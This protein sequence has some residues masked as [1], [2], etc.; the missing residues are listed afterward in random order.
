MYFYL[1]NYDELL[2]LLW[3]LKN[4]DRNSC[5]FVFKQGLT[6]IV[7]VP[8]KFDRFWKFN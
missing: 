3:E 2:S 4:I 6:Y 1:K 7:M 5:M 8:F